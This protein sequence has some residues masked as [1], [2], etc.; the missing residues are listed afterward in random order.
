[1]TKLAL[2]LCLASAAIASHAFAG[3]H[4][5]MILTKDA[6]DDIKSANAA[7][8]K[9]DKELGDVTALVKSS[10]DAL[11][12]QYKDL[13]AHFGGVKAD[14]EEMKKA[15]EKH[16]AD[17]AELVTKHQALSQLVEQIKKEMDAPLLKGGADLKDADT[18]AAIELQRR[19]YLFKGGNEFEF[20]PDM[21]NLVPAADY[22]SA[23][24]K[25][26]RV[27]IDSKETIV[28]S[29]STAERKA[30]DA[31]SMDQAF[32]S[33]QMLGIEIDCNVE[34]A[35][36]VDLYAQVTVSK[37][38][39]MYP[40]VESYGDIGSYQCP[41]KCDAELGPE[42][43]ISYKNGRTYDFRGAFCFQRNVLAEA[44][45]D[46][47]GFMMRAA[48][49]SHRINRNRALI[50]GDGINEPKGWL[51]ADC[52][53]KRKTGGASFNH[54][55]F[56]LFIASAPVEYGPI[57]AT[58]HQNVFAYLAAALDA[59]GRF[60]FGDGLMTYSPDD[61]R[62]R[63]RISNCLPDPTEGG[64][65]GSA[66]APFAANSFIA[67]AGNW[68]MA[69]GAVSKRPMFMEQ[70]VAGSSAWCV[71]Y[72]FGAEDGGFVMCCPAA[73]TLYTGP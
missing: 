39:F 4:P 68:Q 27:G 29:F 36:M 11:D 10:K 8:Q 46:L 33:P 14:S 19:A 42:G 5:G 69:Y 60:I 56:R 37:T 66:A 31:A 22:R 62:E 43:N 13:N 65:K 34:C 35:E 71:M 17:Y 40:Q 73:R 30:F 45:Y 23:A 18:R 24:Y 44:N 55:D 20:K 28:K 51:T 48:A 38:A 72:Q 58:M 7:L 6:P 3:I 16:A 15:V 64:T 53:T 41:A 59:E 32:F 54:Q 70:F 63:I 12:Q 26:M 52:F 1:M 50:T 21:E 49:R 9:L 2:S 61:V 57:V 25:L 47:L 67:A